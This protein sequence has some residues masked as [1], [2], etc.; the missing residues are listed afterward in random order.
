MKAVKPVEMLRIESSLSTSNLINEAGYSIS[1]IAREC[2]GGILTKKI[3]ILVGPG[4]NGEDALIAGQYL[5]KSGAEILLCMFKE[6]LEISTRFPF[7]VE[8]F[9]CS[10]VKSFDKI[11]QTELITLINKIDL[12]IDGFFGT[13]LNRPLQKEIQ[14]KIILV[15]DLKNNPNSTRFKIISIDIPSG[16]DPELGPTEKV[17][18]KSDFTV[19]LGAVKTGLLTKNAKDYTGSIILAP[20]KIDENSYSP[21]QPDLLHYDLLRSKIPNRPVNSHKGTFGK[22]TIIGGSENYLGAPLLSAKA[23]ARSGAGLV[24]LA[25]PGKLSYEGLT[26]L[27]EATHLSLP[28]KKKDSTFDLQSALVLNKLS[29]GSTLLIGPGIGT[30]KQT[31]VFFKQILFDHINK[32]GDGRKI[33]ID[34]DGLSLLAQIPGWWDHYKNIGVLTPHP[35]ELSILTGQSVDYI[36][37]NRVHCVTTYAKKWKTTIVL[38]GAYTVIGEPTGN[39]SINPLAWAGLSSAGT[40]DV[41]AGIITGILSQGKSPYV[42]AQLGTY[43]HSLAAV[44]AA[45]KISA[46]STGLIANDIL[47]YIPM[48]ITKIL[49]RNIDKDV[50]LALG[51]ISESDYISELSDTSN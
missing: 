51:L 6:S 14:E 50:Q 9:N 31:A 33:V 15:N 25:M 39:V 3:L 2:L 16:L 27:P 37:E 26:Y 21:S 19:A 36:Q 10:I 43:I 40:G 13:G 4:I 23:A 48:A 28:S 44:L 7:L 46:S 24:S 29:L 45:K 18:M 30:T 49:N 38:K 35:G 1:K 8:N 22:A 41:L 47:E 32:K 17:A 12:I 20:L 34:A 5:A 42:A 11:D